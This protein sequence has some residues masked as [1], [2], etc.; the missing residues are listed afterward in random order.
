MRKKNTN[1]INDL[2]NYL[3]VKHT[4]YYVN[5]I[6][7]EHPHSEN[8]YGLGDILS[9][10]GIDSVGVDLKD[11]EPSKLLF[12]CICL[13]NN[14]FVIAINCDKSNV[15]Y[16]LN[17]KV[18]VLD[19]I[20]FKEAWNGKALIVTS[21]EKAEEA[22]Y[23]YNIA[24]EL[25][26]KISLNCLWGIPLCLMSMSFFYN[27]LYKNILNIPILILH[28]IGCVIC[29][30]LL[31]NK[32][33]GKHSKR[34]RFCSMIS[35]NGCDAVLTSDGSVFM[36]L[37][38]WSE[39][40]MA[41]FLNSMMIFN[42]FPQFFPGIIVLNY[43]AMMYGLWSIWYQAIIVKKWCT[44]CLSAQLTI[45]LLGIYYYIV[46]L[47]E[48]QWSLELFLFAL[49]VLLSQTLVLIC[50][51]FI[52]ESYYEKI[53]FTSMKKE[54]SYFKFDN[55]V[56][57]AKYTK[58]MRMTDVSEASSIL[59]GASNALYQITIVSN[60]MCSHCADLHK[61]VAPLMVKQDSRIGIRFVFVS[62]N[63]KYDEC[64]KFLIAAGQQMKQNEAAE[65]FSVWYDNYKN[66]D[67]NIK[68]RFDLDL[69]HEKVISE[70]ESHKK[71]VK[72]NNLDKTPIVIV[73]GYI[74]PDS[75]DIT[76]LEYMDR[77]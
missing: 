21:T 19:L 49:F 29:Y 25:T 50:I 44:L 62:F 14:N 27:M 40:G 68:S 53:V 60:P 22:I 47:N 39:V 4:A 36:Y 18:Q 38:S 34:D 64:C 74:M 35:E 24:V 52:V 33:K 76:D 72:N 71:W 1:I 55:D 5:K 46:L 6:I 11:K 75:Y 73:N 63:R 59:F 51:H 23:H 2:L 13:L 20:S 66:Y 28:I 31:Q 57:K 8:M 58:E 54:L 48:I 70:Y 26:E 69:N 65:L 30:L 61:K 12:P 45:W 3:E 17:G 7:E 15:S 67:I 10:F 9:N 37:Y 41:Y 42:L 32:S 43:I 56:L 77:L 16:I